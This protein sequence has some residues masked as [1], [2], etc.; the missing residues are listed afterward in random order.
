MS[1]PAPADDTPDLAAR[2]Y[3]MICLVAL[4]LILL[5]QQEGRY[6]LFSLLPVVA[7]LIG[8]GLRS[9]LASLMLL[10]A[11]GGQ[12]FIQTQMGGP[13]AWWARQPGRFRLSDILLSG[14]VLA[15]VVAH[16]RYIAL[17]RNIIPLDPRHRQARRQA[18]R[19]GTA[20]PEGRPQRAARLVTPAEWIVLAVSVP[21]WVIVAQIVWGLLPG[22]Q[23]N[24]GVRQP[25][26][27]LPPSVWRGLGIVWV[28]GIGLLVVSILLGY[29]A[30]WRMKPE[31]AR[32]LLQDEVW[33]ETR[34]EQR[35]LTRWLAWDRRKMTR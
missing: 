11:L 34:R 4:L 10:L 14:A 29:W 22:Y 15:F 21:V 33:N 24:F 2:T 35:W 32:L 9:S 19:S 17:V 28:L 25:P 26:L 23:A 18:R 30:R 7:G 12:I 1:S 20:T 13:F 8:L 31:E 16:A 6:G 5:A 3:L 27:G